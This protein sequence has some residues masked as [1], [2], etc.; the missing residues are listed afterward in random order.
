MLD[1]R[2]LRAARP[3]RAALTA[4]VVAGLGIALLAIAQA[5][6]LAR[7]VAGTFAGRPRR[8]PG[9]RARA[10]WPPPSRR[11][12]ALAWGVEVAGRH[13]GLGGP[14]GAA[15]GARRPPPPRP[16]RRARRRARRA[17]S[18]P[19]PCQG[20]GGARARTSRAACRRSCS[21]ASC[22]LT[23]LAAVAAVDPLS[24]RDHGRDAPA[25]PVVHVARRPLH[26]GALAPSAGRRCGCCPCTSS[27]S[28]AACPRCARS[29]EASNRGS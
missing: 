3:A 16:A 23:V 18:R 5:W 24:A 11:A 10:S 19:S 8:P 6:L 14:L 21:P 27:T 7:I 20:R 2:L 4:D 25:R 12:A 17:R 1:R 28:S 15:P 26:R 22:P 13:A 9:R 29:T